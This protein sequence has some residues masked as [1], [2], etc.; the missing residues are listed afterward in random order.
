MVV[1]I[2]IPSVAHALELPGKRR[3]TREQYFAVQPIYY[4]GFTVIGGTEPLSI[5]VLAILL[6]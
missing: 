1:A 3:L 5:L 6:V 4:P 2:V